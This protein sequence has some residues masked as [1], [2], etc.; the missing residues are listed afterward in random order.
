MTTN[1]PEKPP[2]SRVLAHYYGLNIEASR[3]RQRVCCPLHADSTPSASV[4]L[5]KNR[6]NCFV[7][8]LSEDSYAVI[9]R[10]RSCG[11][12]EAQE[13]A[14]REFGGD[15]QG[16]PWDVRGE[17][18]RGLRGRARARGSSSAIRPGLCRFGDTWS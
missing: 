2:I 11:F 10:E 12:R 15:S 7:C 13:F 6:W 3:G 4:N 18:R 5:D 8:N 1:S 16:L 9:M 17:P 14:H